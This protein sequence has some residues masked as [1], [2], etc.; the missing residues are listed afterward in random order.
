MN[1][2]RITSPLAPALAVALSFPIAAAAQQPATPSHADRSAAEK[3][4]AAWPNRP[5]LGANQMIAKYGAP[6]EATLERL[7]WQ[8]QGP[9]KRITVTRV[10]HHHDFPKPHMDYI[11]H[12][13]AYR[14]PA[15]KAGELTAYDGSLT[16]DRTRGEMSARCDLEGH[17]ILTLNLANDI[18]TA[19]KSARQARKE[20]GQNVVDDALGKYPPYTTAL[21]FEPEKNNVTFADTPVIPGSPERPI[22]DPNTRSRSKE[23]AGDGEILGFIGA[24]SDNEIV[25]ALEAGKKKLSPAVTAYA[26][27]LHQ[28]HGKNLEATLAL[29]Q[30]INVTPIETAAVDKL[31]VSGAGELA[32]LAPLEGNEFGSAYLLA[33]IK[34]HTEVLGMID[35]QLLKRAENEAVKK[36]LTDTRS[37]VANHLAEGKKLQ[38]S[39]KQ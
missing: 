14:V 11:E 32:A 17:N 29:G 35:N 37:H 12:T 26:K 4:V 22:T 23:S 30:K 13:I 3:I 21:R 16:F 39:L 15:E 28:E 33:M 2:K 9:Y 34:D 31:R 24:V 20:F 19:N 8:N 10:E 6:Q 5:K 1:I 25:A 7:V 38:A 27:M 18:A 36:H